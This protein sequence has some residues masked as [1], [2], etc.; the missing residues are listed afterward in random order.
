MS[1][2]T[3]S[4][5]GIVEMTTKVWSI[6]GHP[7]MVSSQQ[8][9]G[10]GVSTLQ[11][12][13][14]PQIYRLSRDSSNG[15]PELGLLGLPQK[16]GWFT[17]EHPIQIWMKTGATPIF[18]HLHRYIVYCTYTIIVCLSCSIYHFISFSIQFYPVCNFP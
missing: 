15:F 11:Q 8:K 16:N 2:I 6:H 9:A 18:G 10:N 12:D 3:Q 14:R 1:Q 4:I 5:D 17:M 7:Q 13:K